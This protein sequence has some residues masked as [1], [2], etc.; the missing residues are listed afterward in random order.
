MAL[1][2]AECLRCGRPIAGDPVTAGRI[3]LRRHDEPGM[4]RAYRGSLVSCPGSLETVPLGPLPN[5]LQ[6]LLDLPQGEVEH[7]LF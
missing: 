5:A 6:L 7:A 2:R 4:H 1:P 3:R